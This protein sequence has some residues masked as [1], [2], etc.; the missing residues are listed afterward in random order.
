MMLSS[1]HPRPPSTHLKQRQAPR[2]HARQPPRRP[3]RHV[4]LVRRLRLV[5]GLDAVQH[6]VEVLLPAEQLRELAV[7]LAGGDLDLV[8]GLLRECIIILSRHIH[9]RCDPDSIQCPAINSV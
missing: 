6:A 8:L 5:R 4:L 9:Q 3:R 2:G 7:K 1:L